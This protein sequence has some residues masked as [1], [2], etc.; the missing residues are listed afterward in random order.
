M[1]EDTDGDEDGT[2]SLDLALKPREAERLRQVM[3]EGFTDDRGRRHKPWSESRR[4]NRS[5]GRSIR[6]KLG[7]L[8][9]KIIR[10]RD[11]AEAARDEQAAEYADSE[12]LRPLAGGDE[13]PPIAR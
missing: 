3:E 11:V 6:R 2:L 5:N 1:P 12:W 9:D 8:L 4:L 13:I 10:R 7:T